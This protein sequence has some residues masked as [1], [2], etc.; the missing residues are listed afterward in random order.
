MYALKD[1][2]GEERLNAAIRRYAERVRFQ[3]APY[4]TVGEFL[5][6]LRAAT[7]ADARYLIDDLFEHITLYDN[8][9]SAATWRRLPD[10]RYGV[11][12]TVTARKLRA[13]E[14]G[15]ETEIPI[16]DLVDIGVFTGSG[17]A[18]RSLFLEKRRL[19]EREM[20]FEVIVSEPPERAGVDP[21]TKLIDRAPADNVVAVRESDSRPNP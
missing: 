17:L 19:T 12:L 4:T 1:A 2:I 6:E 8:R 3:Q 9:A 10:G 13:D 11:T 16:N 5:E 14:M 7:P 15:N 18:E 20:T 21:Y